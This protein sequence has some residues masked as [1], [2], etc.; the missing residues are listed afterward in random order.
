MIQQTLSVF[1]TEQRLKPSQR[2]VLKALLQLKG[3][4]TMQRIADFMGVP[5]HTIS[6]RFSEL[7]AGGWIAPVTYFIPKGKKRPVTVFKAIMWPKELWDE[8]YR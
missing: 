5:L 3:R 8:V 6:G 7:R 1:V 2:R 4:A